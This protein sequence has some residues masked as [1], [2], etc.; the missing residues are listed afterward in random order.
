MEFQPC[1]NLL[2]DAE[3]EFQPCSRWIINNGLDFQPVVGNLTQVGGFP[4]MCLEIQPLPLVALDVVVLLLKTSVDFRDYAL[5]SRK[6][7]VLIY[8]L[9]PSISLEKKNSPA[10]FLVLDVCVHVRAKGLA[11]SLYCPAQLGNLN[12]K[13]AKDIHQMH[14]LHLISVKHFR[15]EILHINTMQEGWVC[16]IC[17]MRARWNCLCRRKA[18]PGLLLLFINTMVALPYLS[19]RSIVHLFCLN[20]ALLPSTKW[21]LWCNFEQYL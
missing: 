8:A 4:T 12:I 19:V 10:F 16:A 18:N 6:F 7:V 17:E 9:F 2:T 11:G 15:F 21:A 13:L 5:L 1:V 20:R 14:F 3:L